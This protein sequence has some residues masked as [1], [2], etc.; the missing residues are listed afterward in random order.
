MTPN[1]TAS[2]ARLERTA[3]GTTNRASVRPSDSWARAPGCAQTARSAVGMP[4]VNNVTAEP[5]RRAIGKIPIT[6]EVT[7]RRPTVVIRLRNS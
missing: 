1:R 4:T 7:I 2:P 6:S 3:A 5:F